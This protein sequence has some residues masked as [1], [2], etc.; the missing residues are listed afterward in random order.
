M[1][2]LTNNPDYSVVIYKRLPT[3]LAI[4]ERVLE[5]QNP[6]KIGWGDYINDVPEAFF[7][8]HQEDLQLVYLRQWLGQAHIRIY[9]IDPQ[10]GERSVVWAGI[11]G[12]E[13]DEQGDDVIIF[14]HGYI[15]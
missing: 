9:R 14:S 7:S 13:T 4:G 1:S 2:V 8:L 12:T 3:S 11:F 6:K 10:T 5:V 15:A